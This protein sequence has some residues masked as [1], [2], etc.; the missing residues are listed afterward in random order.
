M[1]L[2]TDQERELDRLCVAA[3]RVEGAREQL[4]AAVFDALDADV[5]V[6]RI[7]DATGLARTTILR[8]LDAEGAEA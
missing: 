6:A 1:K 5:P 2:N 7:A 3:N 4:R 8:W